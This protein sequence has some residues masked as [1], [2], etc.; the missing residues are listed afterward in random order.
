MVYIV[1]AMVVI[2]VANLI[3]SLVTDIKEYGKKLKAFNE[4][5]EAKEKRVKS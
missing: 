3:Y 4:L 1:G 5:V 2:S